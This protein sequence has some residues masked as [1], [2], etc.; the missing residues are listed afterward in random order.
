MLIACLLYTSQ[1]LLECGAG[2]T[3]FRKRI[4]GGLQIE[5]EPCRND[6]DQDED[7]VP[8]L[9]PQWLLDELVRFWRCV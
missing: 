6:A 3:Y 7:D 5:R 8:G 9:P 4:G 1:G 2:C